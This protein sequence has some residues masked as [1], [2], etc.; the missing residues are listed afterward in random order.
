MLTALTPS[1][2]LV[3]PVT[4]TVDRL[5]A[6]TAA[7][8]TLVVRG[9]TVNDPPLATVEPLT[10]RADKPVFEDNGVTNNVTV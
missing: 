7:T 2:K 10:V 1:R 5:S 3:V 9:A 4:V 6:A 8:R